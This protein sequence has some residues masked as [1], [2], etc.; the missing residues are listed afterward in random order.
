[1]RLWELLSW[2]P[3][4]CGRRV[5]HP[6]YMGTEIPTLGTLPDITL[7]PSGC[8]CVSF[9]NKLVNLNPNVKCLPEFW[10]ILANHPIWERV[11]WEPP[12]LLP[13]W[14]EVGV[15]WGPS[16]CD[17]CQRWGHLVQPCPWACGGWQPPGSARSEA[18]RATPSGCQRIGTLDCIRREKTSQ[19]VS[20]F[21]NGL[22][23][24][25]VSWEV[26]EAPKNLD[27]LCES[28]TKTGLP[29]TCFSKSFCTLGIACKLYF[30]IF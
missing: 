22:Y 11:L 15:I 28:H 12:D 7:C 19:I 24:N 16:A 4:P 3:H 9:T 26:T 5:T 10:A 17:R 18:D 29:S 8:S 6:N 20:M 21:F 14:I 13:S 2:W 25:A 30:K 23:E 1:M 27:V